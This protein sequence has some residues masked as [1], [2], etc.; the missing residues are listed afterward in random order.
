[1]ILLLIME[2][3]TAAATVAVTAAT[4]SYL[5]AKY[6]LVQDIQ[7]IWMLRVIER[8]YKKA[9]KSAGVHIRRN[10]LMCSNSKE[11]SR[12]SLLLLRRFSPTK[13]QRRVY[14]VS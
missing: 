1:M 9:G 5:D 8:M 14:L 4:A 10:V 2:I 13:P 11:Q 7:G 6:G 3:A 12:L